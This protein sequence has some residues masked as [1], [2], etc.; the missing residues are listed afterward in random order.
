MILS[1]EIRID[2]VTARNALLKLYLNH[3]PVLGYEISPSD[4][5]KTL[6]YKSKQIERAQNDLMLCF[7][8]EQV[9]LNEF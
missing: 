4:D 7:R 6:V 3:V 9:K 1:K 8:Y 5:G 2:Q